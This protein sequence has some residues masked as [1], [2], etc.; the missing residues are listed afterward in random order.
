MTQAEFINTGR[1]TDLKTFLNLRPKE[2]LHV[3]CTDVVVY[4]GGLYIQ[5]LKSGW[6]YF[7]GYQH[8]TLE[9]V[10]DLLWKKFIEN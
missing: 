8:H 5:M 9:G 4:E 2:N 3:D 7:D 10:E 1:I 6:Y